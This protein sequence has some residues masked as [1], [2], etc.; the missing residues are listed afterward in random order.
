MKFTESDSQGY[1]VLRYQHQGPFYGWA[2]KGL[3]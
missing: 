1:N 3:Q 2:L